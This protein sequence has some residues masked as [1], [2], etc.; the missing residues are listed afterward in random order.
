MDIVDV[1][2]YFVSSVQSVSV[3]GAHGHACPRTQRLRHQGAE[4][5]P[6][7]PWRRQTDHRGRRQA[8][9]GKELAKELHRSEPGGLAPHVLPPAGPTSSSLANTPAA[10]ARP[11]GVQP[12]FKLPE[13]LAAPAP[14]PPF[15]AVD[16]THTHTHK[17][18]CLFP[19]PS[20]GW[21]SVIWLHSSLSDLPQTHLN[22]H[23][24]SSADTLAT[25]TP[26][27]LWKQLIV[28]LSFWFSE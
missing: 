11:A 28:L 24:H 13:T 14:Y 27:V 10:P 21:L 12:R 17:W 9:G 5:R 1:I 23:L 26:N 8:G 6:R 15:T 20:Q 25:K 18:T 19:S 4:P 16:L 22:T 2:P 7:W 3:R